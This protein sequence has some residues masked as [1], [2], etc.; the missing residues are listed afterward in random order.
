MRSS[1]FGFTLVELLVVIAI[2]GVLIALL[3]PAVQMAR[4]AARRM[5]CSNNLKQIG[6]GVHNFHDT[7]KG[8]PPVS[9]QAA[10]T[11]T[12]FALIFPYI[13]QQPL[14]DLLRSS[15]SSNTWNIYNKAWWTGLNPDVQK[16]F[17]SVKIYHCP[18]RRGSGS[19][20]SEEL[21]GV[22]ETNIGAGA[23]CDYAVPIYLREYSPGF[24]GA[25]WQYYAGS[26]TSGDGY[27]RP[28]NYGGPLRVS[29]RTANNGWEPRDDMSWFADGTS[30][31]FVIGEKHIPMNRLG[32]CGQEDRNRSDCN[33]I[34]ISGITRQSVARGWARDSGVIAFARTPQDY[35]ADNQGPG[36]NNPG[37]TYA[38]GSY[39]T[40][41][42]HFL[43]G[44]GSVRTIPVTTPRETLNW[45]VRVDDGNVVALP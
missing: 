13:E 16:S 34:A 5:Q 14:Y 17:G 25:W 11:P 39:H 21:P 28:S 8:L 1:P 44:D 35:S 31:Q 26:E 4:E 10:G 7:M 3:L 30:H 12:F 33:F 45:F 6:L 2:I 37:G 24:Y 42:C 23:Y 40:G 38:F 9:V 18:T 15:D 19:G 20:L 36:P 43:I 29:V 22:T 32:V 41:L 27:N